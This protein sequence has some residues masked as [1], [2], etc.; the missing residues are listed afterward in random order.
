LQQSLNRSFQIEQ[1][2][3]EYERVRQL[4][5]SLPKELEHQALVPVADNGGSNVEYTSGGFV[6]SS[7]SVARTRAP[8]AF[9]PARIRHTNEILVHLGGDWF[10]EQSACHASVILERRTQ[11]LQELH[12]QTQEERKRTEEWLDKVRQVQQDQSEYVEIVEPFDAQ[13]EAKWRQEHREKVRKAKQ[14]EAEA[15][16]R[17]HFDLSNL[18]EEDERGETDGLDSDLEEEER[19]L[20]DEIESLNITRPVDQSDRS[21]ESTTVSSARQTPIK[22]QN[23]PEVSMS[24]IPQVKE[25]TTLDDVKRE[26]KVSSNKPMSKFKAARVNLAGK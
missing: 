24:S 16:K 8:L 5:Q 20:Q 17:V 22:P 9:M 19:Q 25:R 3:H 12:R 18:P 13:N 14:Q 11:K 15:R 26:P 6:R 7:V 4:L 21:D 23:E 1:Q 10:V 2:L